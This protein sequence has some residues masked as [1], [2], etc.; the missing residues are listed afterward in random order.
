LIQKKQKIKDNPIGSARLSGQRHGVNSLNIVYSQIQ[1]LSI[2]K[3]RN[4]KKAFSPSKERNP[5][6]KEFNPTTKN[7][8]LNAANCN[9][10]A[11]EYH[12]LAKKWNPLNEKHNS[13]A[14]N[15]LLVAEGGFP[16]AKNCLSLTTK[17]HPFS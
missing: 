15:H 11:K 1:K 8:H 2:T 9:A 3:Y 14:V 4:F 13:F 16:A 17:R 7:N 5:P 12:P 10:L 6:A